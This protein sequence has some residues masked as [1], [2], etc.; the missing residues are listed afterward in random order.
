MSAAIA[1]LPTELNVEAAWSRYR[2]LCLR[3][4][5]SP[6]LEDDAAFTAELDAAAKDW[7]RAFAAWVGASC[8]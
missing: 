8:R 3:L 2:E 5:A 6:D 1:I 7:Q 4:A